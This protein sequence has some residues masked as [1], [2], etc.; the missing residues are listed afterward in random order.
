MTVRREKGFRRRRQRVLCGKMN[1]VVLPLRFGDEKLDRIEMSKVS[2]RDSVSVTRQTHMRCPR[3][4]EADG[5]HHRARVVKRTKILACK[6]Q[7]GKGSRV[8]KQG[9]EV[10]GE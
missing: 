2:E 8:A 4:V 6:A 5:R 7:L 9:L 1:F 10:A 3:R